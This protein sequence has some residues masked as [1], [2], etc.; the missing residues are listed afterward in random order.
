MFPILA[1]ITP[2]DCGM[3][4]ATIVGVLG[5]GAGVYQAGKAKALRIEP[6]PL[7]V[8]DAEQHYVTAEKHDQDIKRL[9]DLYYAN[10]EKLNQLIGLVQGIR[11]TL[12]RLEK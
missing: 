7:E 8:R 10:T 1:D 4:I 3:I 12:A 11:D 2:Q 9:Y 5:G 6:Q